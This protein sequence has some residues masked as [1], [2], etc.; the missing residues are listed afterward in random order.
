MR[1]PIAVLALVLLA[2]TATSPG[3]E[4]LAGCLEL[5]PEGT[6]DVGDCS[7]DA[8]CSCCVHAGPLSASL[9]LRVPIL[10]PTGSPPPT[11]SVPAPP[12]RSSEIPHVPKP[13]LA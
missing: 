10:D 8:C 1:S 5:C 4:A 6:Q 12:A 7:P 2:L 13:L 9:P 11:D 3:I